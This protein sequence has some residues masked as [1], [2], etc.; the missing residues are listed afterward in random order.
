MTWYTNASDL[1]DIRYNL[2]LNSNNV[3]GLLIKKTAK[4]Q[5]IHC[6]LWIRTISGREHV[7]WKVKYAKRVYQPL[8]LSI[9]FISVLIHFFFFFSTVVSVKC[10]YWAQWKGHCDKVNLLGQRFPNN[11]LLYNKQSLQ[12]SGTH[13]HHQLYIIFSAASCRS[14]YLAKRHQWGSDLLICSWCSH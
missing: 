6:F 2:D 12:E 4:F 3:K 1:Y 13:G 10:T 11:M 7:W 5:N 8:C 14:E 9:V